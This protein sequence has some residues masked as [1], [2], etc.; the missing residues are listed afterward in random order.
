M[1]APRVR[2]A[3]AALFFLYVLVMRTSDV[4]NTFLMLGEQTRDWTIALGG[5]RDLPLTGPPSTAGGRG[6]GPVY[7]WILWLGRHLVG[8]FMQNLPHAGGIVVALLQSAADTWLLVVLWRRLPIALALSVSLLVASAPFDVGLS[9]VIWNPPVAAALAKMAIALAL[10]LGA[11]P[12]RWRIVVTAA[13]AWFAVQAHSTAIFVAGPVLAVLVAMPLAHRQWRRSFE[14]AATVAAV[15]LV[16][17]IPLAVAQFRAPGTSLAPTR[18]IESIARAPAVNP[19]RSY[20]VVVDVTGGLLFRSMGTWTFQ[21]S[22]LIAGL[23][24]LARWRHDLPLLA[25]SVGAIVAATALFATWTSPYDSY[26]FLP[27]TS[28]MALTHALALAAVPWPMVLRGIGVALLA[29]VILWQP[30]RIAESKTSFK[31]PEYRAMRLAS[32]TLAAE[33]PVLRDIR[34]TFA[35]HPTMDKYFMYRI[36][37]GRIASD[38]PMTAHIQP[39][40]QVTLGPAR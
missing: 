38:A 35:V 19:I 26:W 12:P 16:L 29:V 9:A 30:S 6:L 33:A 5:W 7:Y 17:Q 24:V 40:G 34:V 28:S 39:D 1:I 10:S 13:V 3:L 20:G 4:A 23:I 15:V 25:V 27:L 18:L 36:L 31:Y 32:Q 21:V 14:V 22:T 2:M 37:G 8:P 11:E